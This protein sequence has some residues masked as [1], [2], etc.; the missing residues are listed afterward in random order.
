MAVAQGKVIIAPSSDV[1]T[2]AQLDSVNIESGLYYCSDSVTLTASNERNANVS[3]TSDRWTV[4]CISTEHA[5]SL[6]C[7]TQ[8]WID[9]ANP[10]SKMFIRYANAAKSAY[11]A[12]DMIITSDYLK[13]NAVLNTHSEPVQVVVS[14]TQP[15]AESGITKLWIDTSGN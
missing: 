15:T 10:Q 12:F 6:A 4:T 8:I 14:N 1:K 5:D 13:T 11:T 2:K 9:S 7:L 3:V